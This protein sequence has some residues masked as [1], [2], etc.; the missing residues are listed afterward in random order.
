M[1][2]IDVGAMKSRRNPAAHRTHAPPKYARLGFTHPSD[3]AYPK[4]WKF[5]VGGPHFKGSKQ[6][7]QR[8]TRNAAARFEQFKDRIPQTDRA[9]VRKAIDLAEKR[10]E[11][12]PY[13][14]RGNPRPSSRRAPS[15]AT[16]ESTHM[17]KK[18]K[19]GT[20]ASRSAAAKK[21][22][23]TRKRHAAERS[24]AATKAAR[25][26]KRHGGKARKTRKTARKATASKPRAHK[27]KRKSKKSR[28]GAG[29]GT[30][31][32]GR[33]SANVKLN[34]HTSSSPRGAGGSRKKG[35]S[36]SKS[37]KNPPRR[38][39][40]KRAHGHHAR[41]YSMSNPR[42]NWGNVALMFGGLLGGYIIGGMVDALI[43]TRTPSGGQHPW[44]GPDAVNMKAARPDGM[45]I[46]GGVVGSAAMVGISIWTGRR[47]WHK[48]SYVVAGLGLGW[49][50]Q[51]AMSLYWAYVVPKIFTV[52]KTTEETFA[53]R[54]APEAQSYQYAST[55]AATAALN[56]MVS[57]AGGDKTK[58]PVG[59]QEP[60]PNQDTP[61]S[62]Y[63]SWQTALDSFNAGTKPAP[64][65]GLAKPA[66]QLESPKRVP[67]P[68]F[69]NMRGAVA[70]PVARTA[71]PQAAPPIEQAA[72]A[73]EP[74]G[75]VAG[76]A[77]NQNGHG[78]GCACSTCAVP[79]NTGPAG[80]MYNPK[81]G[82]GDFAA[83]AEARRAARRKMF[84]A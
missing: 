7:A 29:R 49:A 42:G 60:I 36:K 47:G 6:Q 79:A 13:K 18:K 68:R 2:E 32:A 17:A 50:L 9:S 24:A 25:S 33:A 48:T 3:Y 1:H 30:A 37:R 54:Y 66:G 83:R 76:P 5:P 46:V 31:S 72:P 55:E 41:T 63:A 14:T 21:A 65:V 73:P 69:P 34:V 64:A 77:V 56:K 52:A 75:A 44:V 28:K 20:K 67:L 74:Q 11:I 57:D 27:T 78:L 62:A 16:T 81:L 12:G 22:A 35:R 53:N 82:L 61:S 4:E 71:P 51:T 59:Q 38:H 45:R 26:R 43:A 40:H 8:H 39:K 80:D 58:M 84:A 15:R 70:E 23:R 10:W 19:K